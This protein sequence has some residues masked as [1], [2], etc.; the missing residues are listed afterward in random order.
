[1]GSILPKSL[2]VIIKNNEKPWS[3]FCLMFR[4]IS[5]VHH[6]YARWTSFEIFS[7]KKMITQLFSF[8]NQT[9]CPKVHI[10]S[11][12][13]NELSPVTHYLSMAVQISKYWINVEACNY[14]VS[15]S[16]IPGRFLKRCS[17]VEMRF[18]NEMLWNNLELNSRLILSPSK[19][20]RRTKN[21]ISEIK[22]KNEL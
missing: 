11:L 7:K 21:N 3:F 5:I 20:K 10:Y 1:M 2:W 14:S 15:I 18:N 6:Q 22:Y 13:L 12:S 8:Y 4:T 16:Y 19:P 17:K 9:T